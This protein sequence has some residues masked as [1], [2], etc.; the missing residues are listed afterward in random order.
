VSLCRNREEDSKKCFQ[1][2]LSYRMKMR[3]SIWMGIK[4][5]DLE[6]SRIL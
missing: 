1:H 3:M 6:R 4:S 2:T 5:R